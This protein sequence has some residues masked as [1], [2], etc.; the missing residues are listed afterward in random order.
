MRELEDLGVLSFVCL[1]FICVFIKK[2]YTYVMTHM[3]TSEDSLQESVLP[4]HHALS[5]IELRFRLGC[6]H[7]DLLSRPSGLYQ[8]TYMG[9]IGL[10]SKSWQSSDPF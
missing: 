5:G 4:A 1:F 6:Q 3:W 8:E 2:T 7:L 10:E 9:F